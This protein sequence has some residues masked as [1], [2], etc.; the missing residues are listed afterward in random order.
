LV[1]ESRGEGEGSRRCATRSRGRR[2]AEG[3]RG[4]VERRKVGQSRDAMNTIV[5]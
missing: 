1:S 5:E 3:S 2:E 4:K